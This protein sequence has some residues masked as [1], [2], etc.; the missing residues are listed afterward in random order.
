MTI[1]TFRFVTIALLLFMIG[2]AKAPLPQ[3]G[4]WQGTVTLVESKQVSFQMMLKLQGDASS[5][6]FLV[7]DEQTPIPEVYQRGDSVLLE[8]SE[9]GAAV[10]GVWD[11]ETLKGNFLRFRTDTLAFPVEATPLS[12]AA[13]TA[14]RPPTTDVP[15]VGKF[16]VYFHRGEV[17]DSSTIATF[18]VKNDSIY[19]T[20][21]AQDGDYGLMVGKQISDLL[22]VNRFTGWQANVLDMKR[23]NGVWSGKYYARKNPPVSFTLEPR[24]TL[25]KE[26]PGARMTRMKDPR[27]PFI[28]SGVTIAGDSIMHLDPRF[29]GKALLIDIMGTWCH[30]C[31]DAAPLLQQLY[32]EF[33]SQ[34]LEI[35]GLSF[36]LSD[37]PQTARKN[38]MLYQE[39]FGI[40]FPLLFCGTTDDPNVDARLRSQVEEFFAYPSTFFVGRDGRVKKVHVGFKGPGIGEEFQQQVEEYYQ[41]VR[42]LVEKK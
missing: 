38:L 37:D 40:T 8:I 28:F 9:Y 18:W 25:P 11:G 31:M 35:V 30:N 1:Q 34:G 41:V 22:Q 10:R 14:K 21:I 42:E 24:I 27:K 16:Q 6:Y 7:G 32:K 2:C 26:Q 29:R 36:E 5:G 19:G 17:T 13:S 15:L 3:E 23:E 39:R 33:Q 12:P 4:L 20:F